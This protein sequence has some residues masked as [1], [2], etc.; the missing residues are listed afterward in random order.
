MRAVGSLEAEKNVGGRLGWGWDCLFVHIE[1][2]G[3][4]KGGTL[5]VRCGLSQSGED[6]GRGVGMG[7]GLLVCARRGC[8]CK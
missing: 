3:A 5:V 1:L 6:C 4:S 7:F 8:G 2:A